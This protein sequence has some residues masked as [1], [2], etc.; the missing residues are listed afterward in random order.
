MTVIPP[1]V[2]VLGI[3]VVVAGIFLSGVNYGKSTTIAKYADQSYAALKE[4]VKY[5]RELQGKLMDVSEKLQNALTAVRTEIEYRDRV[6]TREIEKPV[7]KTC[8]VPESGVSILNESARRYN[9]MRG[10]Q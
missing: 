6:I 8:I 10:M 5:E 2:K 1:W 4:S 3:L 7:Y 9:E